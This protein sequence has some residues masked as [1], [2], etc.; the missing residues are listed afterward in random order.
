MEAQEHLIV[1]L[2]DSILGQQQLIDLG[3]ALEGILFDA[4]DLVAAH[5]QLDEVGQPSEQAVRLDPA[6]LVVVEQQLGRVER[7]VA[8]NLLEAPA[9]T[10]DRRPVAVTR[11][12]AFRVHATFAGQARLVVVHAYGWGP[13]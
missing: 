2:I 4:R 6:Q 11:G 10:V 13:E 3:G 7:N 12:R 5:V 8:R 1:N 9:R